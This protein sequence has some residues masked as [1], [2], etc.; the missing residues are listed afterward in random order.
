MRY[1]GWDKLGLVISASMIAVAATA[2]ATPAYAQ[3]R[4]YSFN[5]PPQDLGSALRA[6]ARASKQQV[7]FDSKTVAG[8]RTSGVSGSHSA[9]DALRILLAGSGLSAER[10]RSG[11]Y[12]VR[13]AAAAQPTSTASA[14]PAAAAEEEMSGGADIVVTAQK[15]SE[16][17]QKVPITLTAFSAETLEK[18]NI[19]DI[20]DLAAYTPGFNAAQFSNGKPIFAIR[21]A[22]NT[23][24]AA[25]A[26]KPVGVF[27]DEIY[28]PRFS[29][30]NFGLFDAQSVT[31]LKGPQGT[32]FG[33]NV[34][35]GA[36][37][38]Q[39]REPSL[40]DIKANARIGIGN[41]ELREAGGYVSVPFSDTAAG[42]ITLDRQV[43]DG[44]SRDII[45]RRQQDDADSWAGRA[46]FV[47]KPS[48]AFK[49]RLSA[50]YG[51]DKNNGRS[52][53]ALT[54]SD[55]DRRTSELGIAQTFDRDIAGGSAR[56]EIG[57]GPVKFTSVTGYRY[58]NSFEIFSRSGLAWQKL[59][60]GFQEMAD[61]REIDHAFSQEGRISY[62]TDNLNLIA[63]LF[64]FDEDSERNYRKYRFAAGTGN[65]TLNN[66]YDQDVKTTSVAPFADATWHV[67]DQ[68]D[69]TGGIRYTYE[70]KDARM[71][72]INRTSP[73][74]SFTA[75][76]SRSWSEVTYRGVATFRPTNN[77]TLYG[78]Y[79]TGFTAGGFNTEADVVAA[80]RTP[81]N[82]ER[83]EN[84]ELGVKT[85]FLGGR[86]YFNLAGFTT[87]YKDKQEFV[88]NTLTF[89][90][91]IINAAQ[92]RARG[93]ESEIGFSPISTLTL[94]GTFSYLDTRYN[95]FII[96][97][98]TPA[99]G[100]DLAN[101][102]HYN[103]SVS[104]D[105]DQP[106][107]PVRLLANASYVHKDSYFPSATLRLT[108]PSTDIVNAQVGVASLDDRWRLVAWV[109][110]L[111]KQD[112]PLIISTF[113]VN[114]EWLAPPRTYGLRLSY[115]Y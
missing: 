115:R 68:F 77:I 80:F 113:S 7:T 91:N 51:R 76:D 94:S 83:S 107:G 56:M 44:Y 84:F 59:T 60:T 17:A 46:Q 69:L 47:F 41:Y 35:A 26:T 90:G 71:Q 14:P 16:S 8:K 110:N 32:L 57:D 109:R 36:I 58:S 3:E 81:F 102:P 45:T 66:T 96:P 29:A 5:I 86:G 73:A 21:G 6:F 50:D 85:R 27:V 62:E 4:A 13:P 52:L 18:R 42:S 55:T 19:N 10:G 108:V 98:S 9:G 30:S 22:E 48:E 24:S 111:T 92:A 95:E 114:A 72:L 97:G 34:T 40:T 89:V 20:K 87:K 11:V 28:I 63:G 64:Y 61:E 33:R 2:T 70:K 105:L 67:T 104:A 100:N 31:V 25:G 88:F 74:A 106:I 65:L 23:F 43:R 53:S 39:T 78:S 12:I 82:P 54:L 112:Y 15:R 79:A 37:L 99:T 101:S 49:L 103:Y 93:I 75:T 38:V 1:K